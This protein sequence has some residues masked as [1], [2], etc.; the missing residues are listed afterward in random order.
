MARD[1]GERAEVTEFEEK[2]AITIFFPK[3]FTTYFIP[4]RKIS[5]SESIEEY[6]TKLIDRRKD[7][8]KDKK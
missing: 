6:Y 2:W 7:K 5:F 3:G 1:D 8:K 4:K